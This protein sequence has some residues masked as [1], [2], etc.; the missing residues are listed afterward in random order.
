MST[1]GYSAWLRKC[2]R[3]LGQ[4]PLVKDAIRAFTAVKSQHK[5]NP[6][7]VTYI[8]GYLMMCLPV[9]ASQGTDVQ[10]RQLR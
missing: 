4:W 9:S 10:K 6:C 5:A 7:Q 1:V 3:W 2:G 8:N